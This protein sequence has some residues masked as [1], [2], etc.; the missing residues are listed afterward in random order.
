MKKIVKF[1]LLAIMLLGFTTSCFKDNDDDSITN[2]DI[3]DFVW[4]GMNA[5]YLYKAEIP[6][7]ANNR[8]LNLKN[9]L[10]A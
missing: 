5:V 10:K 8:F 3:N 2:S 1:S 4:K 9:C 6:D 7:L